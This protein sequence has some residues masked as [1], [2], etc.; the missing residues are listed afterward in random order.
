MKSVP[1][2]W[3]EIDRSALL[4]NVRQFRELIGPERTFLA[5]VKA[6]AYGHGLLEIAG[7]LDGMPGVWLGVHSLEEASALREAGVGLPVLIL[8]YVPLD[9]LGAAVR[10]GARLTV[11]GEQ[12]VNRLAEICRRMK[13]KARVHIKVETGT[14]RQGLRPEHVPRLAAAILGRRELVLEGLSSHFANIEDTTDPSYPRRQLEV[15]TGTVA[16]LERKGIRVP[17][18]H[19][20][21]TA[22]TILF[23]D[24]YHTMVRVGIG[25]YGCWPSKETY[26]SCRLQKRRPVELRP[27]LSWRCRVAQV[28]RVPRGA[29]IGYGGTY[30]TTRPTRL[31]VLPVGYSDGYSRGLS[32]ASYVLLRGRRAPV[33]GRVAMNFVV[34]DVTDIPGVR[35]EDAATLLGRDGEDACPA[36][37]LASLTGTIAYEIL[38][39]INPLLPR[40]LV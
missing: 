18:K 17:I 3:V 26:L 38:S 33:R 35:L 4:Q 37:H 22:S 19:M 23:P 15:F 8:G 1:L 13:R 28:K 40:I 20:S 39:R 25:L 2:S 6:N 27:V 12:T 10:L 7:T 29:F 14:H 16:A 11:S 5:A 36:E 24:T 9:G 21:C 31:A 30:R 34:A 32:N